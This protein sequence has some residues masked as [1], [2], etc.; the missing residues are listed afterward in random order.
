MI[1]G[2]VIPL[3]VAYMFS[4]LG[5]SAN[6]FK[7]GTAWLILPVAGPFIS[8]A[9]FHHQYCSVYDNGYSSSATCQSDSDRA[10][11]TILLF[12]GIL[13]ATGF[14][15]TLWGMTSTRHRLVRDDTTLSLRPAQ[16]GRGYG[17]ALAGTF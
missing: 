12:D 14:A 11:R 3:S 10:V 6:D 7:D 5:A 9:T 2:G 8:A 13:Q 4:L 17:F 16:L 15:L 1:V